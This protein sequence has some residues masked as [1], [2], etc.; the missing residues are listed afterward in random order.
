MLVLQMRDRTVKIPCVYI[1]S[2]QP[3]G[4]LYIGVTSNLALRMTQ[5]ID[6]S[7][8]GFSKRYGLKHLVYYETFPTMLGAIAREKQLKE[9]RRA[10]KARLID[11]FNPEWRNLFVN[12]TGE[13]A[14]SPANIAR[15]RC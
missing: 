15:E 2:N 8:A 6:G 4:V 11:A 3:N 13:I 9:W 1:L 12:V 10:W 5:H 7:V 14:P